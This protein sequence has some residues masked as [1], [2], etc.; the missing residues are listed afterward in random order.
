LQEIIDFHV[1]AAEEFEKQ[2][3]ELQEQKAALEK[4]IKDMQKENSTSFKF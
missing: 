1:K 3:N 4:M 2:I